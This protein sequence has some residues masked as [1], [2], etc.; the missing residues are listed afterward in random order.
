VAQQVS[1]SVPSQEAAI[2]GSVAPVIIGIAACAALGYAAEAGG[3][4]SADY[5]FE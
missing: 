2:A 4:S 3:R 5:F 1:L